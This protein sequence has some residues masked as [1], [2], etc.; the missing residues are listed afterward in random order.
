M[1]KCSIKSDGYA[2][3]LAFV[4]F[5]IS[6]PHFAKAAALEMR[7]IEDFVAENLDNDQSAGLFLSLRCTSLYT[8]M[9]KVGTDNKLEHS[10]R[11]E[12]AA[13][14]ALELAQHFQKPRN[15]EYIQ[16]QLKLMA[17]AYVERW[18]KAKAL[19]GNFS[20]DP[21][22]KS[23]LATCNHIFGSRPLKP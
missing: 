11:F 13:T 21:V 3:L 19:T 7:P 14:G 8:I 15:D 12:T 18:L 4:L 5:F 22:I 1:S 2:A 20:D 16:T 6:S 10:D 17:E 23:D 9:W